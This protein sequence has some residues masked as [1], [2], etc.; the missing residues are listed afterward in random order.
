MLICYF[1]KQLT[2]GYEPF[3]KVG[4]MYR[5]ES[6]MIVSLV[7]FTLKP[8]NDR[9]SEGMIR[10][11]LTQKASDFPGGS[12]GHTLLTDSDKSKTR[13]QCF[14]RLLRTHQ[15]NWP[16][17]EEIFQQPGDVPSKS[18]TYLQEEHCGFQSTGTKFRMNEVD[19]FERHVEN[20]VWLGWL[21]S[22]LDQSDDVLNKLILIRSDGSFNINSELGFRWI[23]C[24]PIRFDLSL[25]LFV[26]TFHLAGVSEQQPQGDTAIVEKLAEMDMFEKAF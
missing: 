6:W 1:H 4:F 9:L 23:V 21:N 18:Y 14:L 11:V 2:F 17:H 15:N 5:D 7:E 16:E 22:A 12:P 10:V 25:P 20:L 13:V 24:I 26:S 8:E 3:F 19:N